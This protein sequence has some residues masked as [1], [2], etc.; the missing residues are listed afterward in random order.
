MAKEQEHLSISELDNVI[1]DCSISLL[2]H[3]KNRR[4]IFMVVSK[5]GKNEPCA[6]DYSLNEMDYDNT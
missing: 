6:G 2:I 5:T 3:D 4:K 1:A